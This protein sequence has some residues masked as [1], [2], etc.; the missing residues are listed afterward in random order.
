[1][2]T[3]LDRS[4]FETIDDSSPEFVNFVSIL[5]HILSHRLKGT[6]PPSDV[7]E[8]HKVNKKTAN[9]RAESVECKI[10]RYLR[11][12]QQWIF[13]IIQWNCRVHPFKTEEY[14]CRWNLV[15]ISAVLCAFLGQTT[16]FGYE[17][18]RSFWDYIKAACT[19]VPHNCIRSIE[20]ME[21]V[22][23][24]RAKVR[25]KKHCIYNALIQ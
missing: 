24:S 6:H 21:N 10:F 17:S 8:V 22:R 4:C 20:S 15:H 25:M 12:R 2:K 3:L 5:E 16:W 14:G 13:V 11:F 23:S 19:K 18:P 9:T 1:M 7:T